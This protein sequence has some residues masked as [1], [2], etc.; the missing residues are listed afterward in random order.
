MFIKKLE[1]T[2]IKSYTEA[3]MEFSLGTTAITGHNGAGKTT[4]I[5]AIAWVLFDHLNYTKDEFIRH[6]EK[7]GSVRLT[8]ESGLD[9]REY[10]VYRDTSSGYYIEDQQLQTKLANKKAEVQRFIWLHLGLEPG[11]DLESLFKHAIGVPQGTF[12]AIFLDGAN[13][14]KT[15]FDRLL[16][17]EEY[18]Q[19]SD[20]LR[21]TSKFMDSSLATVRERIARAEGELSRA[22]TVA[23][24]HKTWSL[25]L[26]EYSTKLETLQHGVT[27]QAAIVANLDKAEKIIS[28][29]RSILA[30]Q[31]QISA[32]LGNVEK[33]KLEIEALS[34]KILQQDELTAEILALRDKVTGIQAIA[35]Q[36]KALDARIITLRES[37]KRNAELLAEAQSRSILEFSSAELDAQHV[38]IVQEL[39]DCRADLARDKKFEAE[40]S[41]GL[42]PILS[43]KCLNLKEGET[44]ATFV[45][46]RTANAEERISTLSTHLEQIGR[47]L[48]IARESEK[49]AASLES[50]KDREIE[51]TKEGKQLA[52]EKEELEKQIN[53]LPQLEKTL[54]DKREQLSALN[55]PRSRKLILENII[56]KET[57]INQQLD[58]LANKLTGLEPE[59]SSLNLGPDGYIATEHASEREHLHRFQVS[60]AECQTYISTATERIDSLAKEITRFQELR[61]SL[62]TEFQEKERLEK[63][64]DLTK[65]IR[66]TLKD[67]AP[68]VAKNYVYRV[69]LEANSMFREITGNAEHTLRWTDD[70]MIVLEEDGF[71]RSFSTLSGG[72]QMAAAL[73][74]RLALLK[75][76]TDIRIAFF[77]EPT[78]NM[79][80]ERRENLAMQISNI[81]NFDQLFVISHDDTFE[82]YVDSVLSIEGE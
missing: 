32:E 80:A 38:A 15:A 55:D 29:Q 16:K 4:I 66:E 51:L 24:E 10:V 54:F 28:E 67:A 53:G 41:N 1:L 59:I 14:R 12:T 60:L 65:F 48:F 3:A 39:A 9:E 17:V 82:G 62:L 76:L 45:T 40:I 23:E 71:E 36:V 25:R 58:M 74:V 73:S 43:A 79:D 11:T 44:L 42:C 47:K 26:S 64:S 13:E 21:E 37:Y 35:G 75:Q 27:S 7:K 69:S 56:S 70:Y 30:E 20:K 5:E 8:F 6:G 19:A 57:G 50:Y 31:K 2:N 72:E 77:D 78:T 68:R 33:A 49:F 81:T 34:P 22:E 46:S 52:A 61:D 63:A 18:R